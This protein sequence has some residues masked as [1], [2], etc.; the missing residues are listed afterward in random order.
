MVFYCKDEKGRMLKFF[1]EVGHDP[2]SGK[3]EGHLTKLHW[4]EVKPD[5]KPS[6]ELHYPEDKD[7]Y[8]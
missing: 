5:E 7:L 2:E 4:E 1:T 6:N 8:P 3:S